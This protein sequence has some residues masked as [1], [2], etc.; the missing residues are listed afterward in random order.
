MLVQLAEQ[1]CSDAGKR[2]FRFW[3]AKNGS[4]AALVGVRLTAQRI[5]Y[6]AIKALR[7]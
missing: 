2:T 7:F 3:D 1:K 4:R 6:S 5:D